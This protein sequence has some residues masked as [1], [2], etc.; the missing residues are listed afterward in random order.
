MRHGRYRAHQEPA[1]HV[2]RQPNKQRR[3]PAARRGGLF[4]AE[5][6]KSHVHRTLPCDRAA[7]LETHI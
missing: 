6:G 5:T 3:S 1:R 2:G 7:R 4:H